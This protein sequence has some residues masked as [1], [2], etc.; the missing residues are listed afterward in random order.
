MSQTTTHLS[1]VCEAVADGLGLDPIEVE[2]DASLLDDLGA[3]SIDLL[4][5]LFRIE[6]ASGTKIT[7][8]D[9]ADFLQGGIPDDEFSD[10]HHVVQDAGLTHLE[11][12]LPQFDRARLT[13][14]LE[15]EDVL[16]LFTVQNLV[17]LVAARSHADAS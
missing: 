4:D 1:L 5:V 7:A 15:A 13:Q 3:E 8:A 11:T 16:G 17:D 10:A 9:L 12:V 6:R 14:P 2:P